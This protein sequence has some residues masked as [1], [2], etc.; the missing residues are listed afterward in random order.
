MLNSHPD[1]AG[2]SPVSLKSN[3]YDHFCLKSEV[4]QTN[5]IVYSFVFLHII[6]PHHII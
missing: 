1:F 3:K 5:K 2:K 4:N 6:V